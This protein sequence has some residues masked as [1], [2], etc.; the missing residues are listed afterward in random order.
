VAEVASSA[1]RR[2]WEKAVTAVVALKRAISS[3]STNYGDFGGDRLAKYKLPIGS[4]RSTPS[5]GPGRKVLKFELRTGSRRDGVERR[6]VVLRQH[7]L[8]ATDVRDSRV[9][10]LDALRET[11]RRESGGRIVVIHQ[12]KRTA[13]HT[14]RNDRLE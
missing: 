6:R 5:R 4:T 3:P 9:G 7:R 12:E 8:R 13:F 2:R 10:R 11:P 1:A 14:L